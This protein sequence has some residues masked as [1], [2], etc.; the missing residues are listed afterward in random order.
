MNWKTLALMVGACALGIVGCDSGTGD[1]NN[2]NGVDGGGGGGG[3]G[4][5]DTYFYVVSSITTGEAMGTTAP[6]FNL[7]GTEDAICGQEDFTSPAPDMETGVDN[8]LPILNASLKAIPIDLEAQLET[9]LLAG[10][11][12]LLVQVSGVNDLTNDDS[13]SF[14]IFLGEVPGEGV[15]GGPA[16]PDSAGGKISGGQTFDIKDYAPNTSIVKQTGKI[17]NGRLEASAEGLPLT[18]QVMDSDLTIDI[19]KAKVKFDISAK[20]LS[21]GVIGGQIAIDDL[22]TEIG[23]L[24]LDIPGNLDLGAT[25]GLVADLDPD[26]EGDCQSISAAIV[27]TG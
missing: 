16:A 19:K 2:N 13:V 3:G 12:V 18:F 15:D 17:V 27:F 10:R 6:G 4:G 14:E 7:D 25:L 5:G 24:D 9:A 8:Q 1:N 23:K 11:F 21:N 20:S 22:V 26:G